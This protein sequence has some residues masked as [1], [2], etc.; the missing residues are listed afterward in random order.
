MHNFVKKIQ[1]NRIR[2]ILHETINGN[3]FAFTKD[4]NILDSILIENF[5]EEY[6]GETIKLGYKKVDLEKA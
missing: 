2:E 5:L 3:Q 6:L 1:H 4:R